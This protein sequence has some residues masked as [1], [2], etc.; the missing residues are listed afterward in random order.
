MDWALGVSST[1]EMETQSRL[2][3]VSVTINKYHDHSESMLSDI[4]TLYVFLFLHGAA[5]S[6]LLS[7]TSQRVACIH[8]CG[9]CV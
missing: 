1:M 6:L 2:W 8:M 3:T 7:C 9:M 5:I 4:T